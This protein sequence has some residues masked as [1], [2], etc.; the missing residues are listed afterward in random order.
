MTERFNPFPC[1]E[2]YIYHCYN[3]EELELF[4]TQC[5]FDGDKYI[6]GSEPSEF[7]PDGRII[8]YR[9]IPKRKV[10]QMT[11]QEIIIKNDIGDFSL[12]FTNVLGTI[13]KNPNVNI[14]AN[15]TVKSV[16]IDWVFQTAK[17]SVVTK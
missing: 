1:W 13:I 8:Y 5:Y 15:L 3:I 9:K 2:K 6:D 17:I 14:I 11:V 7:F 4:K 10:K 12:T 16:E